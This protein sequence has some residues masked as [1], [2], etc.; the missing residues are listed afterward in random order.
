MDYGFANYKDT[1]GNDV[2]VIVDL[3]KGQATG[4]SNALEGKVQNISNLIGSA[5]DDTLIGND[6]DNVIA[7]GKGNDILEGRGGYNTYIFEEG[8]GEDTI[9]NA[10][11]QGLLDLSALGVDWHLVIDLTAKTITVNAALSGITN[12][13]IR[14]A[15]ISQILAGSGNDTFVIADRQKMNLTGGDGNDTF[16]FSGA[17][18]LEGIIN[19]GA[20]Y[21]ALDYSEYASAVN[22]NLAAMNLPGLTGFINIHKLI[23]GNGV[24][25]TVRGANADTLF[26]VTAENAGR[27]T[28]SIYQGGQEIKYS[29]DFEGIENLLGGDGNDTFALVGQGFLTGTIDGGAGSNTLDYSQYVGDGSGVKV[30]LSQS[31]RSATAVGGAKPGMIS[32]IQN[33]VS[34]PYNDEFIGHESEANTFIFADNW[35]NDVVNPGGGLNILDLSRMSIDLIITLD[36][37]ELL[38]NGT[39]VYRY[40]IEVKPNS[41]GAEALHSLTVAWDGRNNAFKEIYGSQGQNKYYLN[42]NYTVD[43]YGG[44][45]NDT[46]YIADKVT[47]TGKID[48]RG[49]SNTIDFSAYRTGRDITLT[50]LGERGYNGKEKSIN[51]GFYNISNLVGSKAADAVDRLRGANADATFVL[52]ASFVGQD[53][54]NKYY[55]NGHASVILTF[56]A[57]EILH[58]GSKDDT[59]RISGEQ[60]YDLYGEAGNDTFVF[61]DGAK[62]VSNGNGQFGN[63]DGGSGSNTLDYSA[64]PTSRNFYLTGLGA[65]TGFNGKEKSIAGEY[66]NITNL[67]GGE[68]TDSLSGLNSANTWEITGENSGNYRTNNRVLTFSGIDT[69]NGGALTDHFILRNGASL[70]GHIDGRSGTDTLDYSAYMTDIAVDLT[71]DLAS[72]I[73]RGICSIEN[74]TGGHG[75]DLITGDNNDNVLIGGPGNDTIYGGGGNDTINGGDGDDRLYGEAGNDTLDG[76]DGNDYLNGGDGDDTLITGSGHNVLSGGAGNDRA[77]VAYQSTYKAE[78]N[79]IENWVFLQPPPGPSG[80]GG[81]GGAPTPTEVK[82][83][84]DR[85]VGGTISLGAVTVEIPPEVL[86]ASATITIAELWTED[87]ADILSDGL[88]ISL[89]GKVYEITTSGETYFGEEN[90]ITLTFEFDPRVLPLALRPAIHYYDEEQGRWVEIKTEIEYDEKTG[91]WKAVARVNHLTKFALFATSWRPYL[92]DRYLTAVAVSQTGWQSSDYAVL[93]RGDDFADALSAGPLAHKFGSP[94]LLTKKEQISKETIN[95][96]RR[97]GVKQIFIVGGPEAVGRDVE[98]ALKAL[99]IVVERIYGSDRYETAVRVAEKIGP[100]ESLFLATGE[101]FPDALSASAIASQLGIPILLTPK[102]SLPSSVAGYLKL[103]AVEQIYIL[104]GSNVI[105]REIENSLPNAVRLAGKD[106]YETNI[107]ILDYF[108]G[109]LKWENVYIATGNN[110][111]DGLTGG[112][113]A[114]LTSSPL[115][116]T[117]KTLPAGI[118]DYLKQQIKIFPLCEFIPIGGELAVPDTLVE[119]LNQLYQKTKDN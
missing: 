51:K 53:I 17:G 115:V 36:C 99:G 69:L 102:D 50:G 96:I 48:G 3:S 106:R 9:V 32:N 47:L 75:N 13:E 15:G 44:E 37:N 28:W 5:Y 38:E 70:S 73:A 118:A 8:W 100:R 18:A 114:A 80:G 84:I 67:I 103:S 108:K 65:I 34:S 113:L 72:H 39:T 43:L 95:E 24:N 61:A 110:Y 86:P 89:L 83:N 81:D 66:R 104:G 91:K 57:M 85:T 105:S 94:I 97:L 98:N 88:P 111:P 63:L 14:F 7:G 93:V 41:N 76:G 55:L 10:S 79:D 101:D 117:G 112:V 71:T 4:V 12:N 77:I 62:L 29:F 2:G 26:A 22:F 1:E 27:I 116:I 109:Y 25:D 90:Y 64:Y 59:F 23:G 46:F 30:D 78:A 33:V 60:R 54:W 52:D 92:E 40:Q 16:K 56:T 58:G 119:E 74:V 6:R 45:D 42:A 21:N 31:K 107:A 87:L 68:A 49:G 11:G 82:E 20:G 19:G 35:G